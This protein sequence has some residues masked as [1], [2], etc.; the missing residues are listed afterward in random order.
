MKSNRRV[1]VTGLGMVTPLGNDVPTTW[2]NILG[3]KSGVDHITFDENSPD[4]S[5]FKVRFA[6][7]I[8]DFDVNALVGKKDA[9]RVDPYCY[10][11]IAAA[12]EALKDA[13]IEK[14][15]DEDLLAIKS[16]ISKYF[17][18]RAKDE[19]DKVWKEKKWNSEELL[20]K[21]RRTP[22]RKQQP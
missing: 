14:V 3:C 8:K 1:V 10:Y 7:R 2:K 5:N 9:K 19:A 20:K 22:Y 18:E 11:G 21:H 17:L 4:V 13:G 12:D 6:A 16:L 15:S